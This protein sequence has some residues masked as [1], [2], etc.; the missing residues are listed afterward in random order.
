MHSDLDNH[1]LRCEEE[2]LMIGQCSLMLLLVLTL[3]F[4]VML[5][6]VLTLYFAMMLLL[7]LT[8]YFAMM[9]LQ[10][11]KDW[12]LVM[13]VLLVTG[14]GMLLVAVKSAVQYDP[15]ILVKHKENLEG[16]TVRQYLKLM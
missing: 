7:V 15:P 11:P 6:L 9:L 5:L 16:R 8:L 1:F 12:H 13:V 10:V 4:A 2:I 14:V 3:Y